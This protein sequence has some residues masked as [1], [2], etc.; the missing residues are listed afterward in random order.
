MKYGILINPRAGTRSLAWKK[1]CL[2]RL[3]E[4]LGP[5]CAAAGLD[6]AGAAQLCAA[7]QQLAARV[8]VLIIAGGDGTISD[9]I[10]ALP[11]DGDSGPV[12]GL[13]PIG[14]ANALA[15]AL[16]L[17]SDLI[18]AAAR[19]RSGKPRRI[20]LVLCDNERRAIMTAVGIEADVLRRRDAWLARGLRGAVP[21][22]LATAGAIFGY[23]RTDT[24]V[25][26]D[27]IRYEVARAVSAIVT[28]IPSYAFG[29]NLVPQAHLDDG[30]LHLL[31]GN[32]DTW[33]LICALAKAFFA[34]NQAGLYRCGRQI[35]IETAQPR[36]LETDGE[37]FRR[38]THFEFRIL[39]A[40]V[41]ILA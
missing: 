26:V 7:A 5:D 11:C 21:Y 28:K 29:L 36:W 6:T 23:E 1:R 16:S 8:S 31:T 10:N 18:Q 20:D 25:A 41:T 3:M 30:Q 33:P 24:C 34:P 27:G 12:L 4:L 13:V 40:A 39:P 35:L 19:I 2:E 22:F 17:P 32:L 37:L 14:S 15:R 9:V 38:A